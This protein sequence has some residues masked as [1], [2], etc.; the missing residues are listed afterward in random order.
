MTL[1]LD[2]GRLTRQKLS[3]RVPSSLLS[4]RNMGK[5][6]LGLRGYEDI[7]YGA[8]IGMIF[9]YSLLSTRKTRSRGS[10]SAGSS[11]GLKV[12]VVGRYFGCK[13]IGVSQN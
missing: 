2:E 6:Y 12:F 8:Y 5:Y 1:D 9:P 10:K 13:N 3:R 11:Q 7:F 4:A